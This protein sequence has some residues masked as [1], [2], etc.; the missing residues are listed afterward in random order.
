MTDSSPKKSSHRTR[1]LFSAIS[2]I[3]FFG[4]FISLFIWKS[5]GVPLYR[6]IT[7]ICFSGCWFFLAFSIISDLFDGGTHWNLKGGIFTTLILLFMLAIA[8]VTGF[9][10][11]KDLQTKI[12]Y[13]GYLSQ[14]QGFDG[15][16]AML[17]V[18]HDLPASDKTHTV[19]ADID[20]KLASQAAMTDDLKAKLEIDGPNGS[21]T[22]DF[23]LSRPS[24]SRTSSLTTTE[25]TGWKFP[26]PE[27]EYVFKFTYNKSGAIVRW[28]HIELR[29]DR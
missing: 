27:G 19:F 13:T 21:S 1:R 12:V 10:A 6:D 7:L 11:F 28:V 2:L 4:I 8:S 9:L 18:P 16:I 5:F 29:E 24:R 26:L 20:Y 22:Y 14:V 23:Y 25:R 17:K 15:Y 3:S